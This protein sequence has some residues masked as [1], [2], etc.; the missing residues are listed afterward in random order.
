[1]TTRFRANKSIEDEA[2][3]RE[4]IKY[5]SDRME[6]AKHYKIP[7]ERPIHLPKGTKIAKKKKPPVVNA[8][9]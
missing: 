4:L 9:G 1:M 2:K 3:V 5:G 8:D 7:F 6:I